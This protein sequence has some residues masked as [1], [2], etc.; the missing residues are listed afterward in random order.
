MHS[1]RNDYFRSINFKRSLIV[2]E[3]P[4]NKGLL[5]FLTIFNISDSDKI[6]ISPFIGLAK[7]LMMKIYIWMKWIVF[8]HFFNEMLAI[9]IGVWIC[10]GKFDPV[11]LLEVVLERKF[12]FV[13]DVILILWTFY[14]YLDL[15]F[16]FFELTIRWLF[17]DRMILDLS[18]VF[19][20]QKRWYF[21]KI[22]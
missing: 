9:G 10:K 3:N 13:I 14:V 18:G 22:F 6:D 17:H 19:L 21:D 4:L 11:L 7:D 20:Y 15:C 2:R 8:F 16:Q 1:S 12:R 5:L